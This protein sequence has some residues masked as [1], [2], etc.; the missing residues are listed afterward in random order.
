MI[1]GHVGVAFAAK[2]RWPRLPLGAL[3]AA[4]FAPDLLR[5]CLALTGMPWQRSNPYSHGFP[6]SAILAVG[7]GILAWRILRDRTAGVVVFGLV[8]AHIA[9]DMVSGNKQLWANGPAGID[10]GS[11]EQ[12]ELVIEA[13]LLLTGWT[14]MRRLTRPRWATH[15]SVPTLLLAVQTITLAGSISQRPYDI[16]CLSYPI[17]PCTNRSV[18][19]KRWV[20]TPFW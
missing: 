10:L 16:R 15:W 13:A 2:W 6:W 5:A 7:A 20:T 4:T 9:L 12:L 1:I 14:L 3:L 17:S 19:T 11:F 18:I 8:V